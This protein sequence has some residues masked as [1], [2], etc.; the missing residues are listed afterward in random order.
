M[1]NSNRFVY[2]VFDTFAT[3][4]I[5]VHDVS[6]IDCWTQNGSFH[7]RVFAAS[8]CRFNFFFFSLKKKGG[9]GGGA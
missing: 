8:R 1:K 6:D 3:H 9:G 4:A 2:D 7:G 5:L